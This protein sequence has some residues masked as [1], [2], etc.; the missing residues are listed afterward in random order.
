MPDDAS[1]PLDA[2]MR[3]LVLRMGEIWLK[4]RN[5]NTFKR[6]LQRN[7]MAALSAEIPGVN[8]FLRR[9]RLVV[10]L[11][12][13]GSMPRAIAICC[14]TPGVTWVSPALP[15][16]PEM[17]AIKAAGL[18]LALQA[19]R[20]ATGSFKVDTRRSNKRFALTSPQINAQVGGPI[21][22]ALNLRVDLGA[23]DR[24]LGIDVTAKLAHVYVQRLKGAGGLPI[25]TVGRVMLML[26]G[27]LDSPVAGYHAQRRGCELDAVY[28]HSPPFI[29]EASKD[30]VIALAKLLA[31]RQERLRLHVVPFTDIQLAIRDADGGRF[32]VL[33]YRRFMYRLAAR[34]AKRRNIPA[35]CNGEN[36]AQVASQT[37]ENLGLVD[38]A[39]DMLCLRPL[40][41]ADKEEIID[42]A[43]R[44]GTYATS[45]LPHEDC[46]TLFI[47]PHP[48]TRAPLSALES[49]E[50]QLDVEGLIQA[51]LEGTEVIK[52]NALSAD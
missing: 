3:T 46:C 45:I 27:G 22:T 23:P 9:T 51:A 41:S 44:I 10:E 14:D 19:W 5:R 34:L 1:R 47:P 33:L 42:Q 28:F 39:T 6:R 49:R 37:L 7:L 8:V 31:P 32:T 43:R 11:P 18:Q 15:V 40:L 16:A 21:A 20:G 38:R 17:E 50:A 29:S 35:L 30:K 36:L 48:A 4:G 26:S 2:P 13:E 52:I 12:D 25:G 24:I